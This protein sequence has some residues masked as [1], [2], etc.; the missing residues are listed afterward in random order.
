MKFIKAVLIIAVIYFNNSFAQSD[1]NQSKERSIPQFIPITVTIGGDFI[2][3]GSFS[4][5]PTQRVDHFITQVYLEAKREALKLSNEFVYSKRI[6]KELDKYSQRN[7]VLKRANGTVKV[8]DLE[9][10]KITGEF[11]NNPYLLNDDVLI[12]PAIDIEKDFIAIEGAVN[13]PRTIQYVEGDKLSDAILFSMGISKAYE[14]VE[15]A[16]ITRLSYDG[17]SEQIITVNIKDDFDLQR[18]DRIR[19]IAEETNKKDFRVTVMGNVNMPGEVFITKNGLTLRDVINKAGGLKS[20]AWIDRIQLYRGD[21][22]DLLL[23][24]DGIT[25]LEI[26]EIERRLRWSNFEMSRLSNLTVDDT[27]FFAV[28]NELRFYNQVGNL[29]FSN[30]EDLSSEAGNFIVKDGDLIIIPEFEN[31]VNVFGQVPNSG[32][33]NFVK[34]YDYKYYINKAGGFGEF[35]EEDEVIL[36]KGKGKNWISITE[37]ENIEIEP[38]DYIWVPK[39]PQRTLEYYLK[40]AGIIAGILG[41]IATI[42]VILVTNSGGN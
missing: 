40:Q 39:E 15:K 9:R 13:K 35:A 14:N 37:K 23:K 24:K 4:A 17:K 38:G 18:G 19:V 34:G 33:Y 29:D 2:I 42:V 3:T 1:D 32:K 12:F 8:I 26:K 20:S 27:L 10:F 31:V 25:E 7:I 11:V 30:M 22:A 5:S 41:P 21:A 36:I 6:L 28:D 16:E